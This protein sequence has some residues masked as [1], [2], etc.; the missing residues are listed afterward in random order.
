MRTAHEEVE[1]YLDTVCSQVKAKEMH[2]EIRRELGCHIEDLVADKVEEGESE[3]QATVWALVQMGDPV[4]LGKGLHQ[5]HKPRIPWGILAAMVLFS[6]ISLLAMGSVEASSEGAMGEIGFMR[7]QGVYIV[8]GMV[9]M[10]GMYFIDVRKLKKYSWLLYALTLF[11][12]FAKIGWDTEI[13]G[14]G[15]WF[16]MGPF[17]IDFVAC[18]PYFFVAAL[19]GIFSKQKLMGKQSIFFN[20]ILKILA[21]LVPSFLFI[22]VRSY[23]ELVIYILSSLAVYGWVSRRRWTTLFISGLYLSGGLIYLWNSPYLRERLSNRF[24]YTHDPNGN[25]YIYVKIKEALSSA[26]W[27]GHG[28]GAHQ[29]NLPYVYADMLPIY[30]IRCF[31]WGGGLLLAALV[32]WFL[33][34]LIAALHAVRNPYGKTL[35]V[36]LGGMLFLRLLYGLSLWSGSMLVVSLPFPFLSY[37]SHVL[38]EYAAV[39]LLLG[40]YRRKDMLPEVQLP[41]AQ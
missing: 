18:S 38:I 3:D 32:V 39:G 21:L 2:V 16:V 22:Q 35:I 36:A 10:L 23:P 29:G 34:K 9:L 1:R 28:F 17:S 8:M 15:R 30:L 26:G 19:A 20:D 27:S 33:I 31:G 41:A 4:Q 24:S 25:G 14:T 11:G 6:A 13:N 40:I 7:N 5:V 37:G 12:V